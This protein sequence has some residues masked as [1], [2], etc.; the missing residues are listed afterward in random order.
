MQEIA[1]LTPP[2]MLCIFR[3]AQEAIQNCLKHS[4]AT[5]VRISLRRV[6]D[7]VV[8]VVNDNGRGFEV[9]AYL[10][11]LTRN[12]HYG[13]VGMVERVQLLNGHLSVH[14]RPRQGTEVRVAL[15]LEAPCVL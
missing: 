8:L 13:L 11:E 15:T 12:Q 2:Q 5:T 3:S 14:S 7:Q 6:D 9:P 1:E 10:S 4:Q